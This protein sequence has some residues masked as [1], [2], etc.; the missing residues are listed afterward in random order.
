V[1]RVE[2]IDAEAIVTFL[3]ERREALAAWLWDGVLGVGRGIGF[4]LTMLG[5][6]ILTPV[7]TFYLLKDWDVL[8]GLVARLIPN[9]RRDALVS[10]GR[11]C[12]RLISRYLHGQVTVALILGALTW[13]GLSI[14]RFPHAGLLGLIVAVFNVIPYL[15]LLLSLVPAVFI[16]LVSGNIA[17]SLLKVAIVYGIVQILEGAVISPRIVGGSVGIHPVS[18]VLALSLGG[19]FFGFVGLLIAVPLAAVIRLLLVR[20]VD[21]YKESA[22]FR[23]RSAPASS[24]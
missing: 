15:G 4:V 1:A 16:A 13:I 3:Q 19:V 24:G 10:F 20:G 17:L 6:L 12:D 21:R 8:T 11:E 23:G 9:D 7:L 14:A 22:L 5:Y 18:V 2:A